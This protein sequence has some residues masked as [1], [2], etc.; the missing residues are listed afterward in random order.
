[1]HEALSKHSISEKEKAPA[2]VLAIV[3][4]PVSLKNPDQATGEQR[5][6]DQRPPEK[7]D[8]EAKLLFEQILIRELTLT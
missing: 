4:F 1:M 5:N 6:P 7:R 8:D 3:R 2:Q